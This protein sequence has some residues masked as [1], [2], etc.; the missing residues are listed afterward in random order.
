[1]FDI[2]QYVPPD[3]N[4][5]GIKAGP[6]EERRERR[7]YIVANNTHGRMPGQDQVLHI[8]NEE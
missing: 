4:P 7:H 3:G 8:M 5:D 6:C 1:V 2:E